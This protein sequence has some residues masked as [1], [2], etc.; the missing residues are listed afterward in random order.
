MAR[1]KKTEVTE[2]T[3]E[4]VPE[5]T[6]TPTVEEKPKATKKKSAKKK[7][8]EP[9]VEQA[10]D[11]SVAPEEPVAEEK[12]VEEILTPEPEAVK[13]VNDYFADLETKTG[14]AP[15][16]IENVEVVKE[17]PKKAKKEKKVEESAPVKEEKA[18]APA[19]ADEF[20]YTAI[21]KAKV[22]LNIMKEPS[23]FCTKVGALKPGARIKI[24]EVSGNFGKIGDNRWV[25]INYIEKI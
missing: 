25:N 24:L 16:I 5:V 21:V 20:P 12:T 9:V 4:I 15:I 23:V 19:T 11:L 1:A 17:K 13:A 6:E 2:T 18:A 7:A 3:P 10:P 14:A 22:V 8:E